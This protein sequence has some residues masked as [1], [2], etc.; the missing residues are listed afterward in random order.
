MS[1]FQAIT[2]SIFCSRAWSWEW[3]T[4]G[5]FNK[6]LFSAFANNTKKVKTITNAIIWA[7]DVYSNS[8][9]RKS[10]DNVIRY[11]Q[12]LFMASCIGR[13]KKNFFGNQNILYIFLKK[14]NALSFY[15]LYCHALAQEPCTGVHEIYNFGRSIIGH[16]NYIHSLS[17]ICLV[18]EK[19][20]HKRSIACSL[21]DLSTRPSTI[22]PAPGS[23]N[24]Q[25]LYPSLAI[26]TTHFVC[27]NHVHE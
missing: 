25:I 24:L 1:A 16:H 13:A 6:I 7:T 4:S 5:S 18:V 26:I 9:S 11:A 8:F 17:D 27:L 14:Y 21:Y 10:T 3:I 23:R 20:C 2:S 19:T 15:D 12:F 22:T